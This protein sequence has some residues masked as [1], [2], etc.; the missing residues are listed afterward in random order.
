MLENE[1]NSNK[2]TAKDL[3]KFRLFIGMIDD[4]AATSK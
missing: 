3:K 4:Q 2:Y 1:A